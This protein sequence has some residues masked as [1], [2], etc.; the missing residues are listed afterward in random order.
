ML[1]TAKT[2]AGDSRKTETDKPKRVRSA[3]R[4]MSDETDILDGEVRVFRT[5]H[6]GNVWQMRMYVPEE[7]KYI[8]L[9]LRTKDKD[10]ALKLA[11]NE[12]IK[13]SAKIQ[14][15]EK[16]FSLSA[17]DFRDR[18]IE[19][20]KTLVADDQ[21]SKGRAGNIRTYTKHYMDFVGSTTKIQNIPHK[22]FQ[23][24]RAF[25]QKKLSTITMT[26]VVN[27]S[28]TIKQM[29]KWGINEGYESPRD[30]RRLQD[31]REWSHE[32]IKQ[33]FTRDSGACSADGA[34]ASERLFIAVGG[35]FVD[36]AKDRMR[37]GNIA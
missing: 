36:C 37:T 9:S 29:Y 14:S 8:R 2:I 16:V 1:Q 20:V 35:D 15:G 19:Y 18:Y 12:Y 10:A 34:R 24:Y 3:V 32:A 4:R 7:K 5:T 21:I 11:R 28:I 26:V 30:L 17:E 6:S 31:L 23:E 22:K 25:R 27:E 33:V 13:F